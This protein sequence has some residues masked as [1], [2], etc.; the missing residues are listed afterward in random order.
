MNKRFEIFYFLKN[1]PLAII[2]SALPG[3]VNYAVILF[4]AS[5]FTMEDVGEFRLIVSYFMLLGLFSL[6]ESSKIMVRAQ[7]LGD[8][9]TSAALFFA[10]LYTIVLTTLAVA[11]AWF[12]QKLTG[13]EIVPDSLMIVAL[14]SVFAYPTELFL[15]YLQAEKRFTGLAIISIAKY[16]TALAVCMGAMI[17]TRDIAVSAISMVATMGVFNVLF[18]I[19]FLG[20]DFL[21]HATATW[22]PLSVAKSQSTHESFTLSLANWLPGTLEHVDKIVIGAVFGLEVLGLY[23]L[24]FST[25]RFI[26][27]ALKPAFYI[28]YRHFVDKLPS[29]KLLW[30]VMASFTVFGALLSLIFYAGTLYIPF[31][32]KFSGGESIVYILFLSYGIAMADAVYTQSYGINKDSKSHRLLIANTGISLFCLLMFAGSTLASAGIALIIC[33]LHYPV[34]HFGTITLLSMINGRT[35]D[36]S[37]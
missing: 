28:Y 15:S 32:E 13:H 6:K 14:I 1:A 37:L 19:I 34:R 16:V 2:A 30:L 26:Y 35:A 22:K 20:R 21:K 33:A 12:G 31:F 7:A 9:E 3:F 5:F 17:A 11:L 29:R 25:G 24:C 10:R 36:R 4:L 27:N 23:T 18:Y 8:N